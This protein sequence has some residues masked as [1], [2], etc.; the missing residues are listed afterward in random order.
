MP[1]TGA[2][3]CHVHEFIK[4][5]MSAQLERAMYGAHEPRHSPALL[6]IDAVSS[7]APRGYPVIDLDYRST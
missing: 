6:T 5:R 3:P 4:Q 7:Q 1:V 2:I